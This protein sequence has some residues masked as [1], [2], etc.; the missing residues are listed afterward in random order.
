M[1]NLRKELA[2]SYKLIENV[3]KSNAKFNTKQ[4]ENF[5]LSIERQ[6]ANNK[7]ATPAQKKTLKSMD[8]WSK[9]KKTLYKDVK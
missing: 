5:L 7:P 3:R 2:I 8:T 9:V 1:E 6:L 4:G